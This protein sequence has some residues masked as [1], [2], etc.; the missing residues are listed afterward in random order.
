MCIVD[1]VGWTLSECLCPTQTKKWSTYFIRCMAGSSV[2]PVNSHVIQRCSGASCGYSWRK[3]FPSSAWGGGGHYFV[4]CSGTRFCQ[5]ILLLRSL[6]WAKSYLMGPSTSVCPSRFFYKCKQPSWQGLLLLNNGSSYFPLCN[7]R[8][9][10][11]NI[12][13]QQWGDGAFWG[14]LCATMI[15]NHISERITCGATMSSPH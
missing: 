15:S 7:S 6:A 13:S 10:F 4:S 8:S 9:H 5:E 1:L 3:T 14:I 2:A 11:W 12:V